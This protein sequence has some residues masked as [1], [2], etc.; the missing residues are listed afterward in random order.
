M[1]NQDEKSYAGIDVSKAMLDVFILPFK[2]HMQFENNSKGIDK[3]V[4]KLKSFPNV[5]IVMEA[6][7][8]YERS[9]AK[10]LTNA[11]LHVSVKN[12]RQIRDMAKGFGKL[13]KT[14]K[15]DAEM[16]ALFAEKGQ[17]KANVCCDENQQKLA[18]YATRRRQLVDMI[19]MEKNRLE[20]A[21][22]ELKKSIHQVLKVLEKELDVI[23]AAQEKSIQ[24]DP[25]YYQKNKILKS[26][27]GVGPIVA[28]EM[29][30]DLPELGKLSP[31]QI[32]A[33]VGLAPFNHDSGTMRGKRA[34]KG[35]RS[36]VR[37][38]LYMSVL[39]AM[40]FNKQIKVFYQRLC[41]AGKLKKV[42]M[43]ACMHKLLII[44]NAMIKNNELWRFGSTAKA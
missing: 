16:I 5:C 27:K 31:R 12:P 44:M 30:A 2:K 6:T 20:K 39:V 19:I 3:L 22:K 14:D 11:G 8:G 25:R 24:D 35:G 1:M 21:N 13:A 32:T 4:R 23:N 37:R 36:S 26:I 43:T 40:R 18:E 7:G 34:I 41:H 17:P 33:L 29:I 42:A 15:I 10:A 28:A 9:S 38:I